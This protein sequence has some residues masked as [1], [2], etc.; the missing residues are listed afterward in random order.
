MDSYLINLDRSTDRLARFRADNAFL[1]NVQRFPAVN[2]DALNRDTLVSQRVIDPQLAYSDGD[3][4]C[5]LSHL[6]LWE[7]ALRS[8]APLTVFEDDTVLNQ[9]FARRSAAVLDGLPEDWDIVLWGWNFDTVMVVDFLPGV[10]QAIVACDQEALRGR[11]SHFQQLDFDVAAQPLVCAFGLMAYSVSPR[12][13][14]KL[15]GNCLPLRPFKLLI[16]GPSF[17]V[18]NRSIDVVTNAYYPKLRAF[19][20]FPPLVVS[21]NFRKSSLVQSQ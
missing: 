13:A 19:V 14:R 11:L 3:L 18:E 10:S 21:P 5:A 4:G 6:H 16:G 7:T 12:G 1:P 8:D 20:C 2:G 17:T 9:H 15:L